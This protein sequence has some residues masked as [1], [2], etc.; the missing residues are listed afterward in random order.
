MAIR[1]Q[2]RKLDRAK[3]PLTPRSPPVI[4]GPFK[5][6]SSPSWHGERSEVRAPDVKRKT[7]NKG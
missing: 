4:D 1:V 2:K 6:N 5:L 7:K 3:P